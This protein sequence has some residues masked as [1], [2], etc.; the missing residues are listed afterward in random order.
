MAAKKS[1]PNSVAELAQFFE[2]QIAQFD[3]FFDG[4][5][6][7][8][9]DLL[10]RRAEGNALVDKVSRRGH[11]IQIARLRGLRSCARD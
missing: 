5:A 4:E 6:H 2:R 8:V 10:V 7:G 3:A 11:G 1:S 9:A